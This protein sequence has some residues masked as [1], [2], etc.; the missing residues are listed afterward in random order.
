MGAQA[1]GS[2]YC[3]E[4]SEWLGVHIGR[5]MGA[6]KQMTSVNTAGVLILWLFCALMFAAVIF[7]E[8]SSTGADSVKEEPTESAIHQLRRAHAFVQLSAKPAFVK[9][10]KGRLKQAASH[11]QKAEQSVRKAVS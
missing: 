8:D 4:S 3:A 11:L 6:L 9:A 7:M 5:V 2:A 1:R 10:A